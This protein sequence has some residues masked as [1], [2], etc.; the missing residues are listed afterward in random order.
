MCE[1]ETERD[2]SV[3]WES[4]KSNKKKRQHDLVRIT[5]RGT[6]VCYVILC[7][8]YKAHLE[9]KCSF[10]PYFSIALFAFSFWI[11]LTTHFLPLLLSL[12]LVV[13][14]TAC[15]TKCTTREAKNEIKIVIKSDL[16]AY[17]CWVVVLWEST[18]IHLLRRYFFQMR[19]PK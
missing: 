15:A 17:C 11:K 2:I 14:W 16:V 18:T 4:R 8:Q 3:E 10:M 7:T 12:S 13:L 9:A 19:L 5:K 1:R 6:M